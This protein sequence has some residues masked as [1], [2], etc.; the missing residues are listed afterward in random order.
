VVVVVVDCTASS[1][2]EK[3]RLAMR[4]RMHPTDDPWLWPSCR[5]A[6]ETGL[7]RTRCWQCNSSIAVVLS[8]EVECVVGM[9]EV[10]SNS[11]R[12]TKTQSALVKIEPLP[13]VMVP[14]NEG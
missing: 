13:G 4:F 7:A 5:A 14:S 10:R 11:E 8:K 1:F 6:L 12:N 3:R 9:D 2:D